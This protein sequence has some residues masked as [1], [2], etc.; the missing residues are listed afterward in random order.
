MDALS[1][2]VGRA[3]VRDMRHK[4]KF[5]NYIDQESAKQKVDFVE[6][7]AGAPAGGTRERATSTVAIIRPRT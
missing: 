7:R 3:R 6:G 1:E 2:F 4:W 5:K